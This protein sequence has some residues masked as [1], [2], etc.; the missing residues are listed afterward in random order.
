M[1]IMFVPHRKHA[2]GPLRPVTDTAF[3]FY[4]QVYTLE[5]CFNGCILVLIIVVY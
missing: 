2:Y 4:M 1:W 5:H 3:L